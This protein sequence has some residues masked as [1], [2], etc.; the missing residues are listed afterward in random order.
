MIGGGDVSTL[1]GGST[2]YYNVNGS[3][4][5]V[6]LLMRQIR[7]PF[8]CI[9]NE[10]RAN[11]D[12][13]VGVGETITFTLMVEGAASTLT[14][15]IAGAADTEAEDLVNEVNV[16]EDDLISMRVVTSATA[17]PRVPAWSM[18]VVVR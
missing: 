9:V 3:P 6:T 8:D 16:D 1:A 18:K 14:C 17:T 5:N 2:V 7:V 13:A 12:A 11:I 10:L 15:Q 4:D